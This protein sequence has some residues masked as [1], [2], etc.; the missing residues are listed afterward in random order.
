MGSEMVLRLLEKGHIV[1][2][3]NRTRAKAARLVEKGMKLAGT[4]RDVAAAADF[5]FSM[6]TNSAALE[7]IV[8]GPDGILAGMAPG[9]VLIDMSTVSPAFSRSVVAK[10]RAKARH[11]GR[12]V[13][14]VHPLQ[15]KLSVM[16]GVVKTPSTALARSCMTLVR[17]SRMSATAGLR[18]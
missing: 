8:E 7:S 15:R 6:V 16:V 3:Y 10:V 1:T 14:G 12:S 2:G 17:K 5:T 18:S 9:K 4:P 13:S 11:G